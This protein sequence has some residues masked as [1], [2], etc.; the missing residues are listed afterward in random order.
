[1]VEEARPDRVLVLAVATAG[2]CSGDIGVQADLGRRYAQDAPCLERLDGRLRRIGNDGCDVLRPGRRSTECRKSIHD[3][4]IGVA[5][6]AN[7]RRSLVRSAL[8]LD[9]QLA[10]VKPSLD[11][12]LD[13]PDDPSRV[14]AQRNSYPLRVGGIDGR[15]APGVGECLPD[16]RLRSGGVE[17]LEVNCPRLAGKEPVGTGED[18]HRLLHER[19]ELIDP[20]ARIDVIEEH[21]GVKIRQDLAQVRGA[22]VHGQGG[23][24]EGPD[25]LLGDVLPELA[26]G[27]E[28]ND[29]AS[30]ARVRPPCQ[31]AQQDGLSDPVIAK[32]GDGAS[33]RDRLER[34]RN[35]RCP[36]H[37]P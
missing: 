5:E 32:S 11:R 14:P 15:G 23:V 3:G 26:A 4:A 37:Q 21:E 1:M 17:A 28:P 24:E 13:C 16:E 25:H 22:Q 2:H 19:V 29:A 33:I 18:E 30:E 6:D 9:R 12:L 27:L 20:G 36:P 8:E 34:A 10:Q 7:R 35:R 31:M